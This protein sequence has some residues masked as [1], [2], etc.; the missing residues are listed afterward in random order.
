MLMETRD[1]EAFNK[2]ES[3]IQT[4]KSRSGV[5]GVN[6]LYEN[7]IS[8]KNIIAN[9]LNERL[10]EIGNISSRIFQ[11]VC[12]LQE[13]NWEFLIIKSRYGNLIV[14]PLF[15]DVNS[16]N[17]PFWLQIL[18]QP[19]TSL[20]D[21]L[22]NIQNSLSIIIS[23]LMPI[24]NDPNFTYGPG[25]L[26]VARELS[27]K[28][29]NPVISSIIENYFGSN[30][31]LDIDSVI[32]YINGL[33]LNSIGPNS[34]R[35]ENINMTELIHFNSLL[36][37]SEKLFQILKNTGISTIRI[38]YKN[39]FH[40]MFPLKTSK[41]PSQE[42]F[43]SIKTQSQTKLGLWLLLAPQV[44]RKINNSLNQH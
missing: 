8:V 5:E 23:E 16:K 31:S 21:L 17:C 7:G 15:F 28:G 41:N 18:T 6:L 19:N 37:N 34:T 1:Q 3:A 24:K 29:E 35:E 2:I 27:F 40:L 39:N 36:A 22:L 26:N 38:N 14:I 43:L 13:N 30:S 4:I 12:K 9:H 33:Y 42:G 10:S 11:I 25:K 20:K 44:I 32:V